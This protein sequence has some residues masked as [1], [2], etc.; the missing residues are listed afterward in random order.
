[1]IT[2]AETTLMIACIV[3]A[4][5]ALH[6]TKISQRLRTLIGPAWSFALDTSFVLLISTTSMAFIVSR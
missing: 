2:G 3:V 5:L 1:M 6:C 4:A